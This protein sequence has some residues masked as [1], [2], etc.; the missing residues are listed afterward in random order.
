MESSLL[1]DGSDALKYGLSQRAGSSEEEWFNRAKNISTNGIYDMASQCFL[2][3]QEPA[4]SLAA[5]ARHYR[6]RAVESMENADEKPKEKARQELK[7]L[8]LTSAILWMTA[9]Q[10]SNEARVPIE[11]AEIRKWLLW[12]T[13]ALE[14]LPEYKKDAIQIYINIGMTRKA[15]RLSSELKEQDPRLQAELTF[16]LYKVKADQANEAAKSAIPSLASA[17]G[18]IDEVAVVEE[19]KATKDRLLWLKKAAHSFYGLKVGRCPLMFD[20]SPFNPLFL[21]LAL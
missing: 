1:K 7:R 16:K 12:G 11:K 6:G 2:L 19:E 5:L 15:F 9:A 21:S 20:S 8:I 18:A 4:R 3:A 10:R 13:G 17:I 14:K